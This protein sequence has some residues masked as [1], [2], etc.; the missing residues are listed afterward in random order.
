MTEKTIIIGKPSRRTQ[1]SMFGIGVL[2][3]ILFFICY[4]G[5]IASCRVWTGRYT[6]HFE[7]IECYIFDNCVD[8]SLTPVIDLI[9]IFGTLFTIIGVI[10]YIQLKDIAITVTDKRVF[11]KGLWGKRVDLPLDSISAVGTS[12]MYGIDVSSSSGTIKFKAIQNNEEIHKEITTLLIDRQN[13]EMNA[14]EGTSSVDA[15]FKLKELLN[16]GIISQEEF[17]KKKQ[18]IL[19]L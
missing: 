17:D 13:K 10:R 18:D 19:G 2:L 12:A 7:L 6:Y 8:N 9:L 15:L 14:K 3:L 5:N 11:G 1:V 16:A 4:A